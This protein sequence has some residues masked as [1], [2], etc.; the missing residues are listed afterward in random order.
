MISILS[1]AGLGLFFA[2]VLAVVDRRLRV[3]VDPKIARIEEVLPGANCGACG[4]TGCH[5]FAEA[6]AKKRIFTANCPP[7]GGEV[8]EK[9]AA[10]LGVS[11]GEIQKKIALVHCGA[12]DFQRQKRAMYAGTETCQAVDIVT[13]GNLAC[14]Y[15]C[16]GFG[17]C[18]R[19]CPLYA[20][21]MKDGLPEIDITKCKGCGK[22]VA[23]CPRN[24]ISLEV[25]APERGIISLACSSHEKGAKVK[26][27]CQV[28]CIG[29]GI[30]EKI[31]SGVFKVKDNLARIDYNKVG[32]D[33]PWDSCMEKC[34]TKC[35]V[36]RSG[37]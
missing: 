35:I 20:I 1:M 18:L 5:A 10:I 19:A 21:E 22:C 24:I 31:S 25:F 27:I 7:G 14:I 23:A 4:F 9:V 28:G 30:C 34:P 26:K 32:E 15:G 11:A 13:G 6:A 8:C 33:T 36:K 37:Q 12:K 29:C 2:L 16:L 3:E 17:D